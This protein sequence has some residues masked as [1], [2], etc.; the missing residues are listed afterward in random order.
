M[1][2]YLPIIYLYHLYHS[3]LTVKQNIIIFG[4]LFSFSAC[5]SDFTKIQ[6]SCYKI[7]MVQMD[8][9]TAKVHTLFNKIIYF[10]FIYVKDPQNRLYFWTWK[11]SFFE[12]LQECNT[13]CLKKHVPTLIGWYWLYSRGT[14]MIYISNKREWISMFIN[15]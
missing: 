13:G 1:C 15:I 6:G 9:H 5:P 3:Q 8:W 12:Y 14:C 2:S 4:Y 11:M 7:N 10:G